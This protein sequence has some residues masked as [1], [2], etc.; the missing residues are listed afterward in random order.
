MMD[1]STKKRGKTF[2]PRGGAGQALCPAAGRGGAKKRGKR[3]SIKSTTYEERGKL[4]G[5]E[6]V[7]FHQ[8]G[9]LPPTLYKGGGCPARLP[10]GK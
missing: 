7:T 5:K 1:H 4:R 8:R 6:F 3:L 10:R 2:A 9:K